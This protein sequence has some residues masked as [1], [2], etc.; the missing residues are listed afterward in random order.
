M[1]NY[2]IQNN[3]IAKDYLINF[4]NAAFIIKE[5]FKLP[6]DGLYSGFDPAAQTY[7]KSTWNYEEGG[8]LT[9]KSNGT[10]PA[11]GATS[12]PLPTPLTIPPTSVPA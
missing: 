8:N 11:A 2:A 1:I 10:E 12:E 6:E 9:G 4:T 5:G 7:D 3:R